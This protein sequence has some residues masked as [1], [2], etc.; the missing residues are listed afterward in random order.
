MHARKEQGQF[1]CGRSDCVQRP[2]NSSFFP[3]SL[4]ANQYCEGQMLDTTAEKK[5]SDGRGSLSI[6]SETRQG[7]SNITRDY[8]L[9]ASATWQGAL[10]RSIYHCPKP[11]GIARL[12]SDD[13][14]GQSN[15]WKSLRYR[16]RKFQ[17]TGPLGV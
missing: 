1:C 9:L 8:L 15:R 4:D 16:Q 14:S 17:W 3:R 7:I 12:F 2:A 11:H 6:V 13:D 5:T 10:S